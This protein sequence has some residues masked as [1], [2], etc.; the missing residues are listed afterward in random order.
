M[1]N[2]HIPIERNMLTFYPAKNLYPLRT[3]EQDENL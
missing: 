2:V 1:S 3:P